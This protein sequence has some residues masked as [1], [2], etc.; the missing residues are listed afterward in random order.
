GARPAR[1]I[2]DDASG[3]L[4][5]GG[6]LV[7]VGVS[8]DSGKVRVNTSQ[9]IPRVAQYIQV[10]RAFSTVA[11]GKVFLVV[12]RVGADAGELRLSDGHGAL[13]QAKDLGLRDR[14]GHQH[15]PAHRAGGASIDHHAGFLID[16]LVDGIINQVEI[17]ARVHREQRNAVKAVAELAHALGQHLLVVH[18]EAAGSHHVGVGTNGASQRSKC[19]LDVVV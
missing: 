10:E 5:A 19:E 17:G 7:P 16:L 18:G 8:A 2:N 9:L 6:V 15:R 12:D 11:D 14:V 3:C 1:Q 4:V 13:L